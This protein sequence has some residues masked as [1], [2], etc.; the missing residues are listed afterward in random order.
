MARERG[1]L[2]QGL[3]WKLFHVFTVRALSQEQNKGPK[4]DE[5][6]KDLTVAL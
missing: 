3:E 5:H 4:Y 1:E 2:R 6:E